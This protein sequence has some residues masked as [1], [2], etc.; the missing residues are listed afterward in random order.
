MREH[1]FPST[2][3]LPDRVRLAMGSLTKIID[4][5]SGL[6]YCLFDILSSPPKMAHTCFDWSDHTARTIDALLLGRAMTGDTIADEALPALCSLLDKGFGADGL[7]YTPDNVWTAEQANMHYQRSVINAL[8]SRILAEQSQ[9]AKELLRG[10]LRGLVHISVKRDGFWYFPAVEYLRNGWFRGD[11]EILSYGT[12][13][14]NTNGRLIYGLCLA[15]ELLEDEDSARLAK[16]YAYH[17]MQHSSAFMSDGGF[18]TGMEFREGHFHSRAVTMLGV[19]RYGITFGDEQALEW[20]KMVFDKAMGYGSR[21]GWFPERLVKERAHGCETCAIVDM[22]EAAI[23]LARSGRLEYW[24]VAE[25]YLRNHLAESQLTS[26]DALLSAR[27]AANPGEEPDPSALEKFIG[28]FTGWSAPNDLLSRVMHNWDLYLCCCAQGVRGMFNAWTNAVCHD[29]GALTVNILI[30]YGDSR[31]VMRSWLP[32]EGRLEIQPLRTSKVRVRI[33]DWAHTGAIAVQVSG[34]T[35]AA[36]AENGYLCLG[37]IHAGDIAEI[38]FE[39]QQSVRTETILDAAY[40]TTW[41]GNSV[42]AME[43]RGKM[44]PLYHSEPQKISL[45]KKRIVDIGFHL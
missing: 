43:P 12:D 13:P 2:L 44:I 38:T 9:Q 40:T 7:H 17:V 28:G 3:F 21:F 37:E 24:D 10:L 27:Q 26:M 23:L 5:E 22:M 41:R 4:P 8:L 6:P 16:N 29:G 14:A 15:H 1:M 25:R 36:K 31:V 35:L 19:I 11:W 34:H 45:S 32:W 39:L 20:G 33:P 30:N 18:A 42:I